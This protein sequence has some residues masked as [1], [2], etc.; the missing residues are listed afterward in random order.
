MQDY[1]SNRRCKISQAKNS[2][3]IIQNLEID[4]VTV[5]T[6]SNPSTREKPETATDSETDFTDKLRH[7]KENGII[8]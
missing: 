6:D 8:L 7:L 1:E 4:N 3:E 2:T 5:I